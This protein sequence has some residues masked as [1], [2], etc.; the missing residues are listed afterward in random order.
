MRF[1]SAG[2]GRSEL[3]LKI[4]REFVKLGITVDFDGLFGGIADYI[5]VVAPSQVLVQF[6][7]CA[8]VNHAIQVVGQFV[9]KLRAFHCVPSPLLGFDCDPFDLSL[10]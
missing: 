5:A 6:S 2:D 3:S 7:L 8:G 1:A 9:E 10:F 4:F